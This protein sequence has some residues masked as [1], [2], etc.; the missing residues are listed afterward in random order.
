MATDYEPRTYWQAEAWRGEKSI[1]LEFPHRATAEEALADIRAVKDTVGADV[2]FFASEWR[3]D[4]DFAKNTGRSV[5][6]D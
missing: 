2:Q 1:N 5:N 6:L 3:G 4:H